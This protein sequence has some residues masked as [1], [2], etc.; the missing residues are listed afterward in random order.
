MSNSIKP[1]R[2]AFLTPRFAHDI[3]SG[4][5]TYV[6]RITRVLKEMGHDPE[7]FAPSSNIEGPIDCYG[8]RVEYANPKH[9]LLIRILCWLFQKHSRLGLRETVTDISNA[10]GLA[11]AFA[12]RDKEKP[13]DLVH[14]IDWGLTGL[15]INKHNGR[16]ILTRCVW[17]R[18]LFTKVEGRKWSLDNW[19]LTKLERLSVV[20]ADRA[21][22]PSRFLAEYMMQKYKIKLDVI[23]PPA[24]LEMKP[25]EY[26]ADLPNKYLIHFAGNLGLRKG[27]DLLAR[28][29]P[30]VW[31]EEPDFKMVLA[32]QADY[33]KPLMNR[34]RNNWKEKADH[35]KWL[36][37]IKKPHLYSVLKR[38]EA[39]VLPS[40]CD[41][42]P[43]TVIECLLLG[44]PVIGFRG[45]SVDELVE[46]RV[47]GYLV[48]MGDTEALAEAMI[49]VWRGEMIFAK[50]FPPL[51]DM[52]PHIAAF[53]LLK[54]AGFN[55]LPSQVNKS[56]YFDP[57]IEGE[58]TKFVTK[59]NTK[60][61]NSSPVLKD[62]N[63]RSTRA[64]KGFNIQ[65]NGESA[66]VVTCENAGL[67]TT[68]VFDDTPLVTK[69]NSP[70]SL[71]ANLPEILYKS[72]GR[73]SVYLK[74]QIIGE[75][76]HLE[77]AVQT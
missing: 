32:G 27:T 44:I 37:P 8:I 19:L 62:L 42:L 55:I 6:Y 76:N 12:D 30:L 61:Y 58:I 39:A 52:E 21:Y 70:T 59:P 4:P 48:P 31:Q 18:D 34:Y 74:D 25:V 36:G 23:R 63:P 68:V 67:W 47:N 73:Y 7:V 49:R 38:A 50:E 77:F 41:N 17:A 60:N 53:N 51:K 54:F 5:D 29:L 26:I 11:K 20:K 43:N 65:P 3:E 46:H 10:W 14:C 75:S 40:R 1:L 64:G 9:N 69:Y 45:A 22:A 13:F 28:A 24:L 2:I 71:T 35:V 56:N 16:Q 72:P 33:P 66:L 15:F 57:S